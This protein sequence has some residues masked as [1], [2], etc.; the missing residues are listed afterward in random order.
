[1]QKYSSPGWEKF[2]ETKDEL[3]DNLR[4]HICNNCLSGPQMYVGEDG[5][6]IPMDDDWNPVV[7]T[8]YEGIFYECRD[9]ATLLNTSC[10]C[11][12]GVE[13]D[14]KPYWDELYGN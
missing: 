10:G 12:Y 9:I 1:M 2:Y 11:E 14:G 8:E 13:V 3:I 6:L 7:D 4:A 5:K